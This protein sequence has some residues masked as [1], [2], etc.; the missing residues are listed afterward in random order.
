MRGWFHELCFDDHGTNEASEEEGGLTK[1]YIHYADFL[2]FYTLCYLEM[3]S[4]K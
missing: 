4:Y 1:I 3:S 2:Y